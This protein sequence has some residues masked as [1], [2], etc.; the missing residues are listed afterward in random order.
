MAATVVDLTQTDDLRDVVHLTVQ[1]LAEGQVVAF[2]TETVY[3]LAARALD[4]QAVSRL[5]D[6]KGRANS[7]PLA[8]AVGDSEEALDYI[9]QPVPLFRRLSRRCWPGPVT[10]VTENNDD[11]SLVHQ[12]PPSVQA[13][14]APGPTLGFRVPAESV[15]LDVLKFTVGPLVLTSANAS[16][17]ADAISGSQVVEQLGKDVDLIL[18][19]GRTRF[20]QPSTVVKVDMAQLT[21]LRQGVLD[22]TSLRQMASFVVLVVCTGN[23][24]R[25]PMGECLIKARLCEHLRLNRFSPESSGVIVQSGGLAAG[26]GSP[27]STQA[28]GVMSEY[29]LDLSAHTSQPVTNQQLSNADIILTMTQDHRQLILAHRPELASRVHTWCHNGDD[30]SDPI[31]GTSEKYRQCARQIDSEIAQWIEQFELEL[32]RFS[33]Q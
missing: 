22:K 25:S 27:A 5:Q 30:V 31:G 11:A 16:G 13:A 18:D 23:T 26:P 3:G 33:L 1:A 6:I 12:L 2:P 21:V 19:G 14:V 28:V 7:N 32:F 8:L 20:A 9:P 15:A 4:E 10:L 29:Q 17:A 24:C